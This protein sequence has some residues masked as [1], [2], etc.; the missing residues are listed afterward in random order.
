M[1]YAAYGS[2]LHPVRLADRVPSAQLMG[3]AFLPDWSLYFHKR[4]RDESGKCNIFAGDS[5]VYFAVF[6]VS[7]EDKLALD[8]IE[9]LGNGYAGISLSIPDF[10]ICASYTAEDTHIDDSLWPYD[11]YKELVL[12]GARFH[13]FPGDYLTEIERVQALRDPDSKRDASQWEIVDRVRSGC[14]SD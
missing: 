2:N 4:S 10:G 3:T 11:W 12:A 6:E 13:G 8:K 7:A 5:G 14:W 1:L 9:G